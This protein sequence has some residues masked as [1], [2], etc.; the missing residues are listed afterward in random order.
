MARHWTDKE[1]D[2]LLGYFIETANLERKNAKA[3]AD[4]VLPLLNVVRDEGKRTLTIRQITNHYGCR[5]KHRHPAESL[6][7]FK[8]GNS[9]IHC[10]PEKARIAVSAFRSAKQ[11]A[12]KRRRGG[13]RSPDMVEDSVRETLSS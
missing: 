5:W 6:A 3:I 12:S 4:E 13:D 10:G 1:D 7:D 8:A 11:K 2:V 9:A